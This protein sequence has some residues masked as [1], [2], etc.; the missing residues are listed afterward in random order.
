MSAIIFYVSIIEH[1]S[2]FEIPSSNILAFDVLAVDIYP[3][4]VCPKDV[5]VQTN[6][7]VTGRVTR[8]HPVVVVIETISLAYLKCHRNTIIVSPQKVSKGMSVLE[9]RSPHFLAF[10]LY[11][12]WSCDCFHGWK[13]RWSMFFFFVG[14]LEF[15][16]QKLFGGTS[17]WVMGLSLDN[18][19]ERG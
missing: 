7:D 5:P 1:F 17:A 9:L 15:A 12:S 4:T 6:G 2:V 19:C 8:W 16:G 18:W 13:S 14:W 10:S 3:L 11:C